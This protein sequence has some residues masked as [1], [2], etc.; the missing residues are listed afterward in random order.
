MN[1]EQIY[2][3]VLELDEEVCYGRISCAFI[4]FSNRTQIV[5]LLAVQCS[6]MQYNFLRN[7]IAHLH[8]QLRMQ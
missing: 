5:L 8:V 1:T 2:I 4:Q 3:Y 6:T 7:K